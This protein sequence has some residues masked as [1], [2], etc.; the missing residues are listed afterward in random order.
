MLKQTLPA[1]PLTPADIDELERLLTA[2]HEA[3]ARQPGSSIAPP[4]RWTA[5]TAVMRHAPALLAAAR[6]RDRLR[7]ALQALV[8]CPASHL[9]CQ[10][11]I[12][13]SSAGCAACEAVDAYNRRCRAVDEQ[14]RKALEARR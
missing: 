8:D 1:I 7:A 11:H 10:D 14:A 5:T 13:G 4:E 6:E 9:G 12:E 2:Y 3:Q